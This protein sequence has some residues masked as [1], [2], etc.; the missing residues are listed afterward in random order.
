MRPTVP[1]FTIEEAYEYTQGSS[2]NPSDLE[3]ALRATA[4]LLAWSSDIGNHNADGI[5]ASGLASALHKCAS[6]VGGYQEKEG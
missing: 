6:E 5:L 3:K 4:F 2:Q 1:R